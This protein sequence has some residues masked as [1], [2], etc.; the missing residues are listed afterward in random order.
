M[1]LRKALQVFRPDVLYVAVVNMTFRY[2]SKPHKVLEPLNH[3]R[4]IFVVIN[5]AHLTL[6]GL[7]SLL[8][9][10]ALSGFAP[11]CNHLFRCQFDILFR[12]GWAFSKAFTRAGYLMKFFVLRRFFLICSRWTG[13]LKLNPMASNMPNISAFTFLKP[14]GF[15][16]IMLV[17][18]FPSV[19][20]SVRI[21]RTDRPVGFE[22]VKIRDVDQ[23]AEGIRLIIC[24]RTESQRAHQFHGQAFHLVPRPSADA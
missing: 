20:L 16:L 9:C 21:K 8:K 19:F 17:F 14:F 12:K 18:C 24:P 7:S 3:K 11:S 6:F 13:I 2:D 1:A 10:S 4:I 5:T 22:F 15:R 23:Y